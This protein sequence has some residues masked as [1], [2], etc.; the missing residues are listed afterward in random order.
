[1]VIQLQFR[2]ELHYKFLQTK[3]MGK[4][5]NKFKKNKNILLKKN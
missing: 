3:K 4:E 1:M 5:S 2:K